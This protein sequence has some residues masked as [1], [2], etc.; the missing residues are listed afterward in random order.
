MF[1]G[2]VLV[3]AKITILVIRCICGDV[4][5]GEKHLQLGSLPKDLSIDTDQLSPVTTEAGATVHGKIPE[6]YYLTSMGRTG[7]SAY[8][9]IIEDKTS[10]QLART[11]LHHQYPNRAYTNTGETDLESDSQVDFDP[12]YVADISKYLTNE[13]LQIV[14]NGNKF[15]STMI[16]KILETLM[17]ENQPNG[18]SELSK[19]L[20][21]PENTS[22]TISNGSTVTSN[23]VSGPFF[24]PVKTM[25]DVMALGKPKASTVVHEQKKAFFCPLMY[26][27][28]FSVS[29][30][31]MFSK[32]IKTRQVRMRQ[33]AIARAKAARKKLA[34]AARKY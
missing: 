27:T 14:T 10:S 13:I 32:L 1:K 7:H 33:H 2:P 6:G 16:A 15:S 30:C 21:M 26:R 23:S 9:D 22:A 18:K 5:F 31:W 3:A 28:A 20:N 25:A 24:R 12:D 11:R 17:L 8:G 19:T 34:R 29:R 4:T